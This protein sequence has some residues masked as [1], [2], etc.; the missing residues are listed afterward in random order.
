M[1]RN[2]WSESRIIRKAI[3]LLWQIQGALERL[4][5]GPK[6]YRDQLQRLRESSDELKAELASTREAVLFSAV[7]RALTAWAKMEEFLVLLVAF[8]LPIRPSRAGLIM[9]SIINF[10]VWL[11]IIHDLM[12]DSETCA[13][14]LPRWNKLSE[15]IRRIKD[16]RDQLAH[17]SVKFADAQLV[18]SKLD[19]RTKT[20]SSRPLDIDEVV[21]FTDVV[22]RICTDLEKFILD[23]GNLVPPSDRKL[24]E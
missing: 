23:V 17:H 7:G 8:V 13:P 22:I 18:P 24:V 15:R 11:S 1:P 9:Y 16:Q 5:K 3:V 19:I 14:M 2:S 20:K 12:M 21:G 6:G 10:N 4:A